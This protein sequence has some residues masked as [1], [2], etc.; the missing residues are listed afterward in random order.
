MGANVEHLLYSRFSW[1]GT[2]ILLSLLFSRANPLYDRFKCQMLLWLRNFHTL[3]NFHASRFHIFVTF[4]NEELKASLQERTRFSTFGS[5]SKFGK[6][7]HTRPLCLSSLPP[8]DHKRK[9]R[10]V[11]K[12]LN[13]P[14][15]ICCSSTLS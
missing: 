15:R 11:T 6:G 9:A 5:P 12:Q 3:K 13:F 7:I 1:G 10:V 2:L 4:W 8:R 14:A